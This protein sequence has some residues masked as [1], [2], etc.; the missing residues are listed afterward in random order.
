MQALRVVQQ[1]VCVCVCVGVTLYQIILLI[2]PTS[3]CY[4]GKP[5]PPPNPCLRQVFFFFFSVEIF[6]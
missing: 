3:L 5:P 2:A 1:F 4:F 6:T